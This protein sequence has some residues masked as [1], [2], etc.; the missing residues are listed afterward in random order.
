[1]LYFPSVPAQGDSILSGG[2]FSLPY[3]SCTTAIGPTQKKQQQKHTSTYAYK[4]L[5]TMI[6]HC[7]G[8]AIDQPAKNRRRERDA[9][10]PWYELCV[11]SRALGAVPRARRVSIPRQACLLSSCQTSH[12]V[13][14]TSSLSLACLRDTK[15]GWV[16]VGWE[17]VPRIVL[18][19]S[20]V[21]TH[22]QSNP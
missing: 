5:F 2:C 13:D 3:T 9:K 16:G 4:P 14:L 19:P 22:G 21:T 15:F 8:E 11:L 10:R 6:H 1:M 17:N 7:Y 20:N 12:V 18:K